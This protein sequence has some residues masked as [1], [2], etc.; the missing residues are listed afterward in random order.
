MSGSKNTRVNKQVQ[1]G[2]TRRDGEAS[3]QQS[4][5]QPHLGQQVR[6]MMGGEMFFPNI[7]ASGADPRLEFY[8]MQQRNHQLDQQNLASLDPDSHMRMVRAGS[9]YHGFPPGMNPNP[10][11]Q[12]MSYN[13]RFDPSNNATAAAFM[14]ERMMTMRQA[15]YQQQNNALAPGPWM[16]MQQQHDQQP[17]PIVD[18]SSMNQVSPPTGPF[19][20]GQSN[21]PDSTDA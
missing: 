18:T 9:A 10:I 6:G 3:L 12:Q 15:A 14:N 19:A 5:V 4:F 8:L 7:G 20:L 2:P 13:Q 17:P 1:P 16:Q 21:A 11:S